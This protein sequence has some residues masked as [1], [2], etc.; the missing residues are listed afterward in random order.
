MQ[1]TKWDCDPSFHG[2]L[3]KLTPLHQVFYLEFFLEHPYELGREKEDK[4]RDINFQLIF[5]VLAEGDHSDQYLE[6]ESS[7]DLI[8]RKQAVVRNMHCP[9]NQDYCEKT[10]LFAENYL[11]YPGYY[12]AVTFK[13]PYLSSGLATDDGMS[14]DGKIRYNHEQLGQL[15][16]N[17]TRVFL[18]HDVKGKFEMKYVN[19]DFT[20]FEFAV[21]YVA[22]A[23]T[24]V[25]TTTYVCGLRSSLE[26]KYWSYEQQ[27]VLILSI[28]LIFF[29]D[30]FYI[31]EIYSPAEY[32]TG[33]SVMGQVTFLCML[34]LF[35][36]CVLDIISSRAFWHENVAYRGACF[37]LPKVIV[38]LLL[39]FFTITIYMF[40]RIQTEADP[41]YYA[42]DDFDHLKFSKAMLETLLVFYFL[43]A[44]YLGCVAVYMASK[45]RGATKPQFVFLFGITFIALLLCIIGI[46]VGAFAPEVIYALEFTTFFGAANCYVWF[47]CYAYYPAPGI[48]DGN[49]IDGDIEMRGI[50]GDIDLAAVDPRHGHN[51]NGNGNNTNDKGN[52]RNSRY[53]QQLDDEDEYGSGGKMN[54]FRPTLEP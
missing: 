8:M 28:L 42:M 5:D 24:L 44:F 51:S 9:A 50:P 35:F 13:H 49:D 30:P 53:S 3:D 33:I 21:K 1:C 20:K 14:A 52:K 26:S 29:D 36:L 31:I 22:L 40:V 46:G 34:L 41:T 25:V 11:E 37:Y 17:N 23:I 38:C 10:T 47:M 32:W 15:A 6:T 12:V 39:W 54:A 18:P 19:A 48:T 43:Y 45:N 16:A 7:R 4:A 27:W 2:Y